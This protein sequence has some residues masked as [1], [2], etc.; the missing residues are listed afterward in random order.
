M[1]EQHTARTSR[2]EARIA[3]LLKQQGY[4]TAAIGKWHVGDAPEFLPTKHGFDS[5]FG[6]PYSNDMG[7]PTNHVKGDK[8]PPLPLV[9]DQSSN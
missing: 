7:G 5:Y 6:L 2:L 1:P 4:A 3:E 8:R 9:Q